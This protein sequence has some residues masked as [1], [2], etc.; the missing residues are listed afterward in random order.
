MKLKLVKEGDFLGKVWDFEVDKDNNLY[1]SRTQIGYA[2]QDTNPSH[3]MLII[4]QRHK[5]RLDKFSV[6]V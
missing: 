3:A 1:M 5:E 2:L 6:G 4:H